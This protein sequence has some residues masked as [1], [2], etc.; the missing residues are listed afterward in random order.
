MKKYFFPVGSSF[1]F[2]LISNEIKQRN[3]HYCTFFLL[4]SLLHSSITHFDDINGNGG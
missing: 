3:K 1:F 2:S 4:E